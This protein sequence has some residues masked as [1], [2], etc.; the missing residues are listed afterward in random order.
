MLERQLKRL[1]GFDAVIIDD[2]GY[3]QQSR[4]EMEVLF[5]FLSERYERRTV[6]ITSNLVFS[7]WDKI[8]KDPMTTAAAIDRIVHH[9]TILELNG[10]SYRAEEAQKRNQDLKIGE[11]AKSQSDSKQ[12]PRKGKKGAKKSKSR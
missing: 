6:V 8:F 7:E 3:I 2:I 12:K 11:N 9:A 5:T 4:D 10:P 1:D